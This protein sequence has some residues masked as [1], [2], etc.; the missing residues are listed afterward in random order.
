[1]I[2]NSKLQ[3]V[4]EEI[5]DITRS[6]LA[7]YDDKGRLTARTFDP[8]EE[9]TAEARA[10]Q[11]SKAESQEM[12]GF[13]FFK[14]GEEGS[15]RYVLLVR[16][17]GEFSHTAG[18]L[19][20]SQIK[21]LV[22]AQKEQLDRNS[23]M[24]N[25][26]LGNFLTVDML[27]RAEKLKILPAKRICYVVLAEGKKDQSMMAA[28]RSFVMPRERDFVTEVDDRSV[29]VVKDVRDFKEGD[30]E[31]FARELCDVL[32]TEIMVKVRVGYGNPVE[33]LKGIPK[34][35]QEAVLALEVGGIFDAGKDT[36]SYQRLGIGRLIYQLPESLCQMFIQEV[37]GDRVISV[38]EET[39]STIERFFENS[40]NISETARQL[41]VHRNTLV[42]RLER[43]EKEM[44]LDVRRF[45]DAMLFKLAM[46]VNAHLEHMHTRTQG[47]E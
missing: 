43:F 20:A 3:E 44:G 21:N 10:F 11:A 38:D 34:S 19:A 7:L 8:G 15:P 36:V 47:G 6:D 28:V 4:I 22:S 46:M 32:Q 2:T 23:F 40:L 5:R 26:L 30:A 14:A 16:H 35:Y 41:Y 1:M 17:T 45:E 24:Q 25:I 39:R 37:F 13:H 27:S 42:Y 9:L 29:I 33:T 18:R 31:T 12:S